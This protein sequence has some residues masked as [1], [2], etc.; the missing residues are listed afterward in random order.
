MGDGR[1]NRGRRCDANKRLVA[2]VTSKHAVIGIT[3]VA[4]LDCSPFR[5]HVNAIC[6]GCES[7]SPTA[8]SLLSCLHTLT[9]PQL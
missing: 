7:H 8:H 1:R 4:A 5:I 2:Y 6:P 9:L 3:K